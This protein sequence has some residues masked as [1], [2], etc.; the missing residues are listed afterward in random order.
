[1]PLIDVFEDK[2]P[3]HYFPIILVSSCIVASKSTPW[4]CPPA[5]VRHLV[6]V[7]EARTAHTRRVSTSVN[8]PDR[9]PPEDSQGPVASRNHARAPSKV[10][11]GIPTLSINANIDVRKWNWTNYLTLGIGGS[12]SSSKREDVATEGK[13]QE[14]TTG[15]EKPPEID[16]AQDTRIGLGAIVDAQALKDALSSQTNAIITGNGD[17]N[18]SRTSEASVE[19]N[20]R[21]GPDPTLPVSSDVQTQELKPLTNRAVPVFTSVTDQ[22]PSKLPSSLPFSELRVHLSNEDPTDTRRR[23]IRYLCVRICISI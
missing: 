5:L 7:F 13:A 22:A 12:S 4:Q 3:P 19:A 21:R 23:I 6:R 1:M 8:A 17:D 9:D 14:G 11:L 18:E 2:L 15:T 10:F 20:N 16:Q